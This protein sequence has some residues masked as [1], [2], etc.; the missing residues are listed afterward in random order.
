MPF[1]PRSIGSTSMVIS[2][3]TKDLENA[4]TAETTPFESAVNIPLAQILKPIK[5]IA[6]VQIRF[7]YTARSKTGYSGRANTDTKGRVRINEA[8]TVTRE[9]TPIIPRLI[10]VNFLSFP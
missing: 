2:I 8:A 7:P 5:K 4:S 1:T 10:P 6:K 9:I 3:N